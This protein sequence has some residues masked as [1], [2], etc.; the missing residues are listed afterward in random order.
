[1]NGIYNASDVIYFFYRLPKSI[2][3]QLLSHVSQMFWPAI[4]TA[5]NFCDILKNLN[6]QSKAMLFNCVKQFL[7]NA[8]QSVDDFVL[9][10]MYLRSEQIIQVW[11]QCCSLTPKT[12]RELGQLIKVLPSSYLETLVASY[13]AE[14]VNGLEMGLMLRM[15]S[16]PQLEIM[17]PWLEQCITL[18]Q[19]HH[20]D[21][22][23]AIMPFLNQA[24]RKLVFEKHWLAL[25]GMIHNGDDFNKIFKYL[26]Y[27]QIHLLFYSIDLNHICHTCQDMMLILSSLPVAHLK[28]FYLHLPQTETAWGFILGNLPQDKAEL[29][30]YYFPRSLS[31][32]ESFAN[33]QMFLDKP[34]QQQLFELFFH[35]FVTMIKTEDDLKHCC[36]YLDTEQKKTILIKCA[37]H[38]FQWPFARKLLEEVHPDLISFI[39]HFPKYHSFV[40]ALLSH[41]PDK[42]EQEFKCLLPQIVEHGNDV[43]DISFLSEQF[44]VLY[45]NWTHVLNQSLHLGM[46]K[47]EEHTQDVFRLVIHQKIEKLIHQKH[48]IR[49]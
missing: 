37:Y 48:S 2:Q 19:I 18:I 11:E 25:P 4:Q 42:I 45:P 16:K 8:I 38:I 24:Q 33:M 43:K 27:A 12:L 6:T 41:Q 34:N 28:R 3:H 26:D 14:A 15:L 44:V 10:A 7:P 1:M 22:F 32:G 23:D 17:K 35:K 40:I 39:Q 31:N 30:T 47:D 21:D 13:R 36:R 29:L 5:Q 46:S 9:V 20:P 49:P